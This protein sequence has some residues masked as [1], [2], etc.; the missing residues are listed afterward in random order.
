VQGIRAAAIEY[1]TNHLISWIPS[2]TVRHA[3]YRRV[4]SWY[5]GPNAAVLTGQSVHIGS[6]RRNG[7]RVSIGAGTVIDHDCLLYTVGGLLIGE[8]VYISPGVWLLTESRDMN[9]PQLAE[10]H[11]PIVIDDYAWIGARAIILG[12]VTIGRGAV[13]QAGAL[14]AQ[15]LE[16]NTVASG[17]PARVVGLRELRGPSYSLNYHPLFG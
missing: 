16:P 15:D 12:G 3:W 11:Q 7:R 2:Y 1:L 8:Q 10:T 14:V 9:H 6:Q 5:L 17:V 13:V 4:L